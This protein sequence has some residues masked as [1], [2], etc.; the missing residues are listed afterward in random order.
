MSTALPSAHYSRWFQFDSP[1][2]AMAVAAEWD[3]QDTSKGIE[4]AVMP[5]M[6]LASTALDQVSRG[7][8]RSRT[9]YG[10][11]QRGCLYIGGCVF[12]VTVVSLG[13]VVP[14]ICFAWAATYELMRV[15]PGPMG[16]CLGPQAATDTIGECVSQNA[17]R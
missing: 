9:H 16:V 1:E 10:V 8:S 15:C 5:L 12:E 13:T 6:A 4:P 3:A 2:L 7:M 11:C 14:C 17:P